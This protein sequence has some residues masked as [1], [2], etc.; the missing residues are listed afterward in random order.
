MN[1]LVKKAIQYFTTKEM[2]QGQKPFV[3]MNGS[4]LIGGKPIVGW[5]HK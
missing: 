2:E 4:T 3:K 5:Y 1:E